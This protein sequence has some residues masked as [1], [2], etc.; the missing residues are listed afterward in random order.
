[1]Q[2]DPAEGFDEDRTDIRFELPTQDRLSFGDDR[3]ISF[4]C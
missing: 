2:A 1:M 4:C 3:T